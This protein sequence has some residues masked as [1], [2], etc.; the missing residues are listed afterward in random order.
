MARAADDAAKRGAR[1]LTTGGQSSVFNPAVHGNEWMTAAPSIH[2][3]LAALAAH[4]PAGGGSVD[5]AAVVSALRT[6][7]AEIAP[8]V[9]ITVATPA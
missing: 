2:D 6:A 4:P 9:R 1:F 8:D 7:L 5:T 3:V